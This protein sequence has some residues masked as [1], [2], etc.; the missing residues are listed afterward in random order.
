MNIKVGDKVL[1]RD[2]G[3][4]RDVLYI[5][6]APGDSRVYYVVAYKGDIPISYPEH[7]LTKVEPKTSVWQ[8]IYTWGHNGPS[9][10]SRKKADAHA[11]GGRIGVVRIDTVNGVS[12]LYLE[13]V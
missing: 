1:V 11:T 4:E 10:S 13:E 12:T 2:C 3:F 9:H 6:Q 7:Q 8:N 5:H